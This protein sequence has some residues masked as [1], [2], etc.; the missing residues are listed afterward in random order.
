MSI[1]D[2]QRIAAVKALEAM[3]YA[4]AAGEWQRPG[5][6]L[7]TTAMREGDALQALLVQRADQLA[8]EERELAA[9]V[10]AIEAYEG[11]R[12]PGGKVPDGKG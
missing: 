3:G 9:I 11:K 8:D 12:W 10:T 2:R 4:F 5:S 7:A 1:I 6:A